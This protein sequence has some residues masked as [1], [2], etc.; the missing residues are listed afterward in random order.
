MLIS[1]PRRGKETAT[2]VEIIA[3]VI[4]R[5]RIKQTAWDTALAAVWVDGEIGQIEQD[6][7][8]VAVLDSPHLEGAREH[9]LGLVQDLWT[10]TNRTPSVHGL[11]AAQRT[12]SKHWFWRLLN[13]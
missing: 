10:C 9:Y 4:P 12:K 6:R 5:E 7:L 1:R 8:L 13:A 11:L 3:T 2:L